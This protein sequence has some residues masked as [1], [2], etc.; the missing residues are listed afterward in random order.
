MAAT[1][2][3]VARQGGV[4]RATVACVFNPNSRVRLRAETR[5]RVRAAAEQVGY[6]PNRIAQAMR[7]RSTRTI[8]LLMSNLRTAIANVKAEQIE[9]ALSARDYQVVIGFTHGENDRVLECARHMLDRRVD[10]LIVTGLVHLSAALVKAL[11]REAADADVPWLLSDCRPAHAGTV[12]AHVDRVGGMRQVG[13][14]LRAAGCRDILFVGET[15]SP[16]NDK[17]RGLSNGLRS[18]KAR[19]AAARLRWGP[20]DAPGWRERATSRRVPTQHLALAQ[21]AELAYAKGCEVAQWRERPDAVAL[22]NDLFAMRFMQGLQSAGLR[23][24]EDLVVTGFDDD[25][26]ARWCRPALTTVRQPRE[27]LA[28]A[29]VD[30]LLG[31]IGHPSPAAPRAIT[32]PCRLIVRASSPCP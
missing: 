14:H 30:T 26:E 10:G 18:V 29:T 11:G 28:Q 7:T 2:H 23:V 22:S 13:E 1:Q 20:L 27:E 25:E 5:Q 4:S 19:S 9:N 17:W 8:G 32:V 3:D 15:P 16:H 24:P 21:L 31:L 6:R 12:A